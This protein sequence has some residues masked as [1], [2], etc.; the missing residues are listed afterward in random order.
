MK[1]EAQIRI[2]ER[3]GKRWRRERKRTRG[4]GEKGPRDRREKLFF[5]GVGEMDRFSG[6]VVSNE[7]EKQ[8]MGVVLGEE[9]GLLVC[10][11]NGEVNRV[12]QRDGLF[13]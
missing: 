10:K 3:K 9:L 5:V 4:P 6:G 2:K 8:L 11:G 13:F 1:G 7:G 12:S